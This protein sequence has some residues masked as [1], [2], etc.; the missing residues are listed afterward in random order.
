[1]VLQYH[2]PSTA[3]QFVFSIPIL[4]LTWLM[5]LKGSQTL[6]KLFTKLILTVQL[7]SLSMSEYNVYSSRISGFGKSVVMLFFIRTVN[8]TKE[9]D[10]M[11]EMQQR[12]NKRG[13]K[14]I[15]VL[16]YR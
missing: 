16:A 7:P 11:K 4:Q 1:M 6:R 12:Y 3:I 14:T 15:S 5:M 10:K 9:Y 13:N 8:A 2:V